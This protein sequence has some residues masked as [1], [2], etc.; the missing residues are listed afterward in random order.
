VNWS[1]SDVALATRW[2]YLQQAFWEA[3]DRGDSPASIKSLNG[4]LRAMEQSLFASPAAR[5]QARIE[6]VKAK[7]ARSVPTVSFADLLRDVS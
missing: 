5:A 6:P 1:L 2:C 7:Q 4:E 3:I